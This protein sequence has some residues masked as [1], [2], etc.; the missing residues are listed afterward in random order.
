MEAKDIETTGDVATP[1]RRPEC[2]RLVSEVRDARREVERVRTMRDD[3]HKEN[4]VLKA[5]LETALAERD[6]MS[7]LATEWRVLIESTELERDG[8]RWRLENA[9]KEEPIV[10]GSTI[11]ELRAELEKAHK[12]IAFMVAFTGHKV[13][14]DD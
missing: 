10:D 3:R 2:E 14:G 7:D 5:R 6:A 8:W 9:K 13:P 12:R 11:T 1:C 4:D